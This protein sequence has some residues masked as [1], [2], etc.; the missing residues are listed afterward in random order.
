MDNDYSYSNDDYSNRNYG[1][2]SIV[3][4]ATTIAVIVNQMTIVLVI[5]VEVI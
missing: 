4:I 5:I 2:V 3:N 1:Y